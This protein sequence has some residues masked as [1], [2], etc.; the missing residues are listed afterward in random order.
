MD[1]VQTMAI[2]ASNLYSGLLANNRYTVDERNMISFEKRDESS[3]W[4]IASH[5]YDKAE[6]IYGD[7]KDDHQT[8]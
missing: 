6:Y 2:I 3:V 7:N 1:K 8:I 4:E 5:I